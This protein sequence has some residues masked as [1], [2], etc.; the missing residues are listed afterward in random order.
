MQSMDFCFYSIRVGR[1]KD[2]CGT[3]TTII[4]NTKLI[5]R[6]GIRYLIIL[7][8]GTP[9]TFEPTNKFSAM[10]GVITLMA[11]FTSIMMPK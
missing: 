2:N 9:D 10:G 11:R 5:S 8:I 1:N 7:A 3:A 6:N 4:S